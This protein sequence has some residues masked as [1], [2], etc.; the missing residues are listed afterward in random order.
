MSDKKKHMEEISQ[1]RSRSCPECGGEGEV[2]YE[3]AVPMSNSNPYGDLESKWCECE[4]CH[5]SGR[6]LCTDEDWLDD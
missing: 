2:E 3:V 6:V 1:W 5:G 4:N